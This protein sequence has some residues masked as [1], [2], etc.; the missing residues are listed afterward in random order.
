M[1]LLVKVSTEVSSPAHMW[2]I[3]LVKLT[4]LSSAQNTSCCQSQPKQMSHLYSSFTL[5][6]ISTLPIQTCFKKSSTSTKQCMPFAWTKQCLQSE[7]WPLPTSCS[8]GL[9]PCTLP[10]LTSMPH[11]GLP[12]QYPILACY[13]TENL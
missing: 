3:P 13:I 10:G 12:L 4:S 6:S 9:S 2:P 1:L 5:P 8:S 7:N 11:C